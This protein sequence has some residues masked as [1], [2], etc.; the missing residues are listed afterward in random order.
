MKP[1]RVGVIGLGV[2]E[3]HV[4]SYQAIPGVVVQAVCDLN[5][6]HL[7]A[8]QTR[9]GIPEA[10]VDSKM[11]TE[12]RDIEVVSI[13]SYD[14]SHA[15]QIISAFNH[16]K[17]VMVEK[18]VALN[19]KDAEKIL[20]AQDDSGL[21]LTSNL[22]LR[23]SPRF[24]QLRK[25]VEAGDFGDIFCIEGDYLHQILW[26]ITSG[27]RGKMDFYS[28]IFGGGIHLIDLMRWLIQDEYAEVCGMGNKVLSK[29]S[30]YKF[31]D[32]FINVFRFSSGTLAKTLTTLGPQ[33]TKFHSLNLYGTKKTFVN[34]SPDAELFT[35]DKI[36][37]M[38]VVKTPYPGMEKGDL[39]PEFVAAIREDTEP[40]VSRTDVFRVMDVCFAA[41]EACETGNTVSINYLI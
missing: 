1:L 22:I 29:D 38:Q 35:G 2:G 40:E 5:P 17:H 37:D 20:R 11:L 6:A 27:W 9:Y 13:C 33:R 8:V 7:H 32:S 4:R 14:D 3:Q 34:H 30:G 31:D 24:R 21:K 12:S 39:L 23:Q 26:K 41:A 28:T 10:F 36:E 15:A 25:W 19:R 16:G 18:P